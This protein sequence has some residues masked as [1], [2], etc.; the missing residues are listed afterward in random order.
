MIPALACFPSTPRAARIGLHDGIQASLTR[1]LVGGERVDRAFVLMS[2]TGSAPKTIVFRSPRQLAV[3][4][5][6]LLVVI[7]VLAVLIADLRVSEIH[8]LIKLQHHLGYNTNRLLVSGRSARALELPAAAALALTV[9]AWLAWQWRASRNA[10]ALAPGHVRLARPGFGLGSW[11]VPG[12]DVVLPV[13]VV[14]E[15]LHVSDPEPER[16]AW[17]RRRADLVLMAW[18]IAFLALAVLLTAVIGTPAGAHAAV[19]AQ[20]R[21]DGYLIAAGLVGAVAA[22]LAAGI[23][24]AITGRQERKHRGFGDERWGRW[25][26]DRLSGHARPA[27]P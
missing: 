22:S 27:P 4:L 26:R 13:L 11:L 20:I 3:V 25:V 5:E 18:W 23:V 17:D 1:D 12:A 6:T 7:A 24:A 10:V 9:P 15:L 2:T 21:R 8:E 16:T 19:T 14:R